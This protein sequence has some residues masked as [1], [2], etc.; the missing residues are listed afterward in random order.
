M[1]PVEGLRKAPCKRGVSGER[2]N[3]Y[4]MRVTS[5]QTGQGEFPLAA[6][7]ARVQRDIYCGRL[8]LAAGKGGAG[9]VPYFW[10][11]Y[12]LAQKSGGPSL[13]GTRLLTGCTPRLR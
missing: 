4:A 11:V 10:G 5:K 7:K 12:S 9:Y 1:V 13:S 6:F 8:S 2:A 3:Y